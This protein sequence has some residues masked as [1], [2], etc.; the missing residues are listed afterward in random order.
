M[1]LQTLSAGGGSH[2]QMGPL[3]TLLI[4]AQVALT[5]AL[6]PAALFY[7]WDGLRLRTGD[8]GFASREFLS[9]TLAMDRSLEAPSAAAEAAFAAR[10]GAAAAAL[11]DRL[12]ESP[13]VRDVTFSIAPAGQELAMVIEAEGFATPGDPVDYNIVQGSKA[14][15]MV[16]YNRVAANFFDAFAVPV[17]LGRGFT[18]ADARSARVIISR[19]LAET[20]FGVTNPLGRRIKYVGR[21]REAI[22]DGVAMERWLEIVGVVADFPVN[23]VESVGRVYHCQPIPQLYPATSAV[24]V[25]SGN[26]EAF[27]A[28]LRDS[29]AAVNTSLQI[30][31]ISTTEMVV[32]REQGLFRLIG[33]SVGLVMLSVIMLSAAGIYA[34]M[35]FTVT[36]RRR[37]I[38][39]RA[40]LGAD[41]NRLLIGIFARAA[42]QL[43]AGAAVGSLAALGLEQVLE[44][45]ML[46]AQ[47]AV[48]LSTVIV[49]MALV[50]LLAAFGPARRGLAIQPIEALREE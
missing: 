50:G 32:K 31:D 42:G 49:I 1:R 44:S 33:M 30:R 20:I 23:D 34:L 38:G 45:E 16:R 46:G 41:R 14:G 2:M 40:A 7:T 43:G 19:T 24:R 11:D 37:E 48:I 22:L 26:P 10:Y 9:A 4:V 8:A 36:R 6:L 15:H 18:G 12:R 17:L 28:T 25:R 21:S 29:A 35:S 27:A 47:R 5:V 39:I 3:W 13:A